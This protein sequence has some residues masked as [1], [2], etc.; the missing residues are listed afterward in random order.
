MRSSRWQAQ[1]NV[2]LVAEEPLTAERVREQVGDADGIL[3]VRER[4]E[5]WLEIAIWNP[6]GSLGGDV[7]QRHAD[8]RALARRAD[9]ARAR[10]PCGSGRA[11]SG[12]A[13]SATALVEQELGPGRRRRARGGRGHPLHAGR[14]R[15]PAC[16]RRGRPGRARPDRPAARDAPALPEPHE[17]PGRPAPRRRR[18]SRRASGSAAWGRPAPRAR[19]RSRSSPRSAAARRPCAFP[20]G[21][22]HVAVEGRARRPA[23]R[24]RRAHRVSIVMRMFR[25]LLCSCVAAVAACCR[26]S[27]SAASMRLYPVPTG[28]FS[29]GLPV[30]LGRRRRARAVGAARS[31]SRRFRPSRRSSQQA[32]QNAALRLAAIDPAGEGQRLHG[33]R[34][35]SRRVGVPA[36]RSSRR[37][38]ER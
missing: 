35:R 28:G 15:Q 4:G 8:R 14:R 37:R 16:G 24:A 9:R 18:R 5:D 7:R 19:A 2:Y 33:R 26:A 36:R 30:D 29:L 21:D 34:R 6:D 38:V 23:D 27:A 31:S 12:R 25:P 11:R 10:S 20:G 22:L 32:S 17:R 1:G 3:E 13:C